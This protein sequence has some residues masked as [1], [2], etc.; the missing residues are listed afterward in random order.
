MAAGRM[1]DRGWVQTTRIGDLE[2]SYRTGR[3]SP[4]GLP[5]FDM[6]VGEITF[7]NLG[8][9]PV[10]LKYS[11]T[12]TFFDG[13]CFEL[14]AAQELTWRYPRAEHSQPEDAIDFDCPPGKKG[15]LSRQ[16]YLHVVSE[17]G[18]A[19]L[20]DGT[21]R[22]RYAAVLLVDGEPLELEFGP[23]IFHVELDR[24]WD[25]EKARYVDFFVARE[26]GEIPL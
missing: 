17:I 10:N 16:D 26:R 21:M 9:R 22:T 20:L 14:G 1:T 18:K 12:D 25:E 13:H 4:R 3:D 23:Q 2:F 24:D 6:S 15:L 7:E 11:V 8:E 5:V 19:S